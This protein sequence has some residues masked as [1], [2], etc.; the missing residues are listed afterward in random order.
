LERLLKAMQRQ[1]KEEEPM[2]FEDTQRL[3]TQ[4]RLKC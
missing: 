1:E 4:K 2:H 3:V